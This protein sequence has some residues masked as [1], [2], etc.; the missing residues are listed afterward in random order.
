MVSNAMGCNTS[1]A[2]SEHKDMDNMFKCEL[3]KEFILHLRFQ[4]LL[5]RT[6]MI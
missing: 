5:E 1:V 2:E 3:G 4:I 6:L